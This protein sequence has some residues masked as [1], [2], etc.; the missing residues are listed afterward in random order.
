MFFLKRASSAL[1]MK[2]PEFLV[3]LLD[4]FYRQGFVSPDL[5]VGISRNYANESA[6][7][8]DSHSTQA[9]VVM[10]GGVILYGPLAC[11]VVEVF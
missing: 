7:E 2:M 6:F 11:T 8:Y 3:V 10:G 5:L 1:S 4:S 9:A